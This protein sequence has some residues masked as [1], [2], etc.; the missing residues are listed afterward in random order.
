MSASN[1]TGT[2]TSTGG[3]GHGGGAGA[4]GAA[5]AGCTAAYTTGRSPRLSMIATP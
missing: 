3:P 2:A 5:P 1:R 4:P